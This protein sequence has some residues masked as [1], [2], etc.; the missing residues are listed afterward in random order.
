MGQPKDSIIWPIHSR[1]SVILMLYS[2]NRKTSP[3]KDSFS[4]PEIPGWSPNCWSLLL[5]HSFP[6]ESKESSM[7]QKKKYTSKP[8]KTNKNPKTKTQTKLQPE[9]PECFLS[10]SLRV[11]DSPRFANSFF[12]VNKS[13]IFL[14]YN[15]ILTPA[16]LSEY[17]FFLIQFQH[18]LFHRKKDTW[19]FPYENLSRK[20]QVKLIKDRQ[21]RKEPA[22]A[23]LG[24]ILSLDETDREFEQ[25]SRS[26][27][28]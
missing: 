26:A 15:C 25:C 5:P 17:V 23:P 8:K 19:C 16:T 4:T 24:K 1:L 7:P 2:Q 13:L 12:S 22:S 11:W 3:T 27:L 21:M 14:K 18:Y 28:I 10:L 20:Y 6:L 9:L